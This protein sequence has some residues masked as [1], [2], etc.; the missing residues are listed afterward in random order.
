M[1]RKQNEKRKGKGGEKQGKRVIKT[2]TFKKFINSHRYFNGSLNSLK[3]FFDFI[4]S[5]SQTR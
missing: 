2:I 1:E 3:L 4:L 5:F